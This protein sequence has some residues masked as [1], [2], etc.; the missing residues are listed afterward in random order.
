MTA[1]V[2]EPKGGMARPSN[3]E[4]PQEY[5]QDVLDMF[6]TWTAVKSRNDTLQKY[7]TGHVPVKNLGV[8][9]PPSFE[10]LNVVSGW[11]A[12]AVQAHAM[13]SIFDGFVFAGE[14]DA[15]LSRLV[16]QNRLRTLYYQAVKASLLYGVSFITVMAGKGNQ[17]AAKVR[18]FSAQQAVALWDAAEDRIKCGLHI[19][20]QDVNGQPTR[21]VAHFSDAVLTFDKVGAAWTC[22][23]EGNPLGRPLME[24]IVYDGDDRPFGHSMLTPELLG[25]IDKSMRDVLRMEVGAE[26]FTAPQRYV[27]GASED[28]FAA[29]D[30]ADVDE[31]T[32]VDS[33]GN[34][35]DPPS[36]PV[37]NAAKLK[38][39]YGALW[40]IT[41]DENGDVPQVGEFSAPGASNFIEVFENDAQRFSGATNVPLAQLGVLSNNYTSSDAL[42]AANDPLILQ[43]ETMNRAN[44]ESM[45]N[46]ARMMM[47]VSEGK[48]LKQLGSK[49]Y[50]VQC[51]L[52]DP[53][54]STFAANAD[55]WT[56]LAATD[57]TIIGTDVMY[58]GIGLPR[59][60]ID[61]L[62]V[63]K[64]QAARTAQMQG[65]SDALT[66]LAVQNM[67]S[68]NM[69][70]TNG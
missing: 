58:E 38:A 61:R 35:I 49:A 33:D 52:K 20:G 3:D 70:P 22:R 37:S 50:E 46:V 32:Y 42:G 64:E 45:E 11:A 6:D 69:E 1:Q 36:Q 66:A 53:S 56:K 60:T 65:V 57:N 43:V 31:V 55:G 54:K 14:P 29:G 12:K 63:Q 9:I 10:G 26:F 7:Y 30:D 18:V 16:Q 5:R 27:L 51:Y 48:T 23:I 34:E 28:L 67:A 44:A 8:A 68:P 62:K 39:Y 4:I 47:C 59:A 40:A 21:Y 13:R 19:A 25:I 17:P 24:P 2:L 15:N 41:R